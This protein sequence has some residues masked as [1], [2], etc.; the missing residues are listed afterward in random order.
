MGDIAPP[1]LAQQLVTL[2]TGD[3]I[4]EVFDLYH[5]RFRLHWYADDVDEIETDH[6]GL[7]KPYNHEPTTKALIDGHDLKTK[8]NDA[9]LSLSKRFMFLRNFSGSHAVSFTSTTSVEIDFSVLRWEKDDF[10]QSMTSIN[11]EGIF[12]TNQCV[13]LQSLST[14]KSARYKCRF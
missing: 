12:Q 11:L 6:R 7:L 5:G 4:V 13:L 3:F 2:R 14:Y 1:F 10:R 9:Y 8:F